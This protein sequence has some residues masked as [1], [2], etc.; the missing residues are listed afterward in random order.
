[1]VEHYL[2]AVAV[3]D[4]SLHG[5]RRLAEGVEQPSGREER[6]QLA[7]H[8]VADRQLC[9]RAVLALGLA[10]PFEQNVGRFHR[11]RQQTA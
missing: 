9:S 1:V 3:V 2:L 10:Q 6:R 11:E 8:R 7:Q 4:R 5:A